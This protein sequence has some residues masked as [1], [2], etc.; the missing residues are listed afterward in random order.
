MAVAARNSRLERC[1]VPSEK[2]AIR[3][4]MGFTLEGLPEELKGFESAF[5][6]FRR[7]RFAAWFIHGRIARN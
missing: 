4:F 6:A 1:D 5:P 3:L 7:A 2:T